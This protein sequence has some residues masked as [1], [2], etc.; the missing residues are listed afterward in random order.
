MKIKMKHSKSAS[1]DGIQIEAYLKDKVYEVGETIT[2]RTAEVFLKNRHAVEYIEPPAPEE[3]QVDEIKRETKAEKKKR[4]A[5]EK[6]IA[7]AALKEEQALKDA[8]EN[9]G[10]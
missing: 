10:V 6:K 1:P 9:K 8:P 5:K 2:Q 4:L 7:D 3:E